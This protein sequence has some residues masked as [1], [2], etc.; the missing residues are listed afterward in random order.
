MHGD[1]ESLEVANGVKRSDV[2]FLLNGQN[3][4]ITK[5]ALWSLANKGI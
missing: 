4:S 1:L 5:S 2:W 3:L